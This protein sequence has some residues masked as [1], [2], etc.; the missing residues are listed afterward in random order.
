MFVACRYLGPRT[1]Q[2]ILCLL[3]GFSLAALYGQLGLQLTF[4]PGW[5]RA[6]T[7]IVPAGDRTM[8]YPEGGVSGPRSGGPRP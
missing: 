5:S 7:L 3:G 2:A 4:S 8:M 6:E 1:W